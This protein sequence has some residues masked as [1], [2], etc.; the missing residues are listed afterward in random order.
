[1]NRVQRY[2]FFEVLRMVL[3]IVGGLA[4]L[5]LLAQGLSRTDLIV[6]SRQSALTYFYVVMLGAPQV[7][8]L[9][10]PLALFVAGIWSLNRIHR[11]SE[12]VVAQAAGMTRWQIASPIMRLAA[13]LALFHLAVNLWV[14]P[15]AQRELRETVREA[16]ADLAAALIR[17]GQF[18][19]AGDQLTF[20]ARESNG[21]ELKGIIISDGRSEPDIDYLA[22]SGGVVNVDGVPNIV[23]RDGQIQQLG[24]DGTLR[25]VDFDQYAFDL[26]PFLKEDG[27]LVLKSSDR[28]LHELFYIDTLSYLENNSAARYA[29]EGHARMTTPL[30]NFAMALLAIIAVMGGDF[31][32]RGYGRRIAITTGAALLL[33]VLQLSVQA[34]AADSVALNVLQWA[35]PLGVIAGLSIMY[36]MKGRRL[37]GDISRPRL[38]LRAKQ[39]AEANG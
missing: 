15:T 10:T 24:E 37:D 29:A 27:E 28:Y 22:Q 3:I 34:A 2:L 38:G 25:V 1:M 31:S 19:S 33:V 5:A 12:I 16:R 30:L 13:F 8:A 36:F 14:Q 35:L 21:S 6:E 17:P 7:I 32:R 18:T 26:S 20:F 9:L 11:D 23:L 39:A 4:L